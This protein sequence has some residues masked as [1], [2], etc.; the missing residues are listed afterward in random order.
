[1]FGDIRELP[2]QLLDGVDAVVH[3]SAVSND[4]M[5]NKFED[6]TGEINQNASIRIARLAA[7]RGVKN[8]V[9]ASSCSMYGYAEGGARKESDPTNP[10]TAYAR[11]KIGAEKAFAELDLGEMTITSLR[12]ATACGMSDR[13][14]L[15]IVLNDFVACALA[16][17][18]IALLSD[19]TPWR[20]LIDVEDMARAISWA[21]AR[22][23][24]NGGKVLAV[25]A[26]RDESNYQV[27]D[28]GEAVKR[29]VP[30]TTVS[31]NKNA[32]PDKRSYKVDFALFR[33]LAPAYLPQVPLNQS[34]A[35]LRE[36]LVAM[37]FA[38]KDFRIR[39]TCASRRLSVTSPPGV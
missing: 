35:R 34:I 24:E 38:D 39:R 21:I 5:G 23:G 31:I 11:S 7:D 13:L 25:N 28:L 8:F 17:G 15:D 20:P 36:G 26:G 22:E 33:S 2:V 10:L 29:Q 30:G 27:R 12:F 1:M 14:R 32:P 18:E 16:S 9:F 3:L 4:P 19:G 6:V 37:G